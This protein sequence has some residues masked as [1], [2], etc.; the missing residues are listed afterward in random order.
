[1]RAPKEPVDPN[2]RYPSRGARAPSVERSPTLK[3]LKKEQKKAID[4]A[5]KERYLKMLEDDTAAAALSDQEHVKGLEVMA[6]A[7][8]H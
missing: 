3:E 8:T 6:K 5:K 4:E 7:M 2:D 1:L